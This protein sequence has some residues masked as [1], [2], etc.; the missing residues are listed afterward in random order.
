MNSTDTIRQ[1]NKSDTSE[2]AAFLNHA[3]CVHRH[4]DWQGV[5][6]W[7]PF[8]PFLI[9]KNENR[10]Q[11]LIACPPDLEKI[12]WI[13]CFACD[14]NDHLPQT[15]NALF[16]EVRLLPEL[17]GTTMY[18]VGLSDWFAEIL[19]KSDFDNYQN[20]VILLWNQLMPITHP[21]DPSCFIR[22][23]EITDI[24]QVAKL[25]HTAFESMWVNSEDKIRLAYTQA[26]HA[27]V[28]EMDGEIIGYE[29]TTANFFS[30]HLARIA[31]HP[32]FQQKH[33]GSNLICEMFKYFKRKGIYQ[34]SVNTQNN[35]TASLALYKSLGFELT[36]ESFP[37]F[38]YKV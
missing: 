22:P 27:S 28:A 6:E 5:L 33:I 8:S 30:A 29:L 35:N 24:E 4:L 32:H 34:I 36:G 13:R 31:I 9:M 16:E 3:T 21:L 23:M 18:S 17:S 11:G 12:S 25:D 7:I 10:I 19:L 15:W 37:V 1:A 2:I 38:R 26:E 20:I 14:K